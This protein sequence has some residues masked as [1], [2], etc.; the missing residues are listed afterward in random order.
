MNSTMPITV[1]NWFD[2]TPNKKFGSLL[3][4]VEYAGEFSSDLRAIEILYHIGEHQYRIISGNELT[5]MITQVKA[6]H[7]LQILLAPATVTHE[8]QTAQ[9]S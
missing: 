7:Q 9:A 4:A 8:R 3:N 1:H 5:A 2:G 6:R